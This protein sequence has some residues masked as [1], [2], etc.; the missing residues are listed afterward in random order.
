M[1][2]PVLVLTLVLVAGIV[3]LV[4][5]PPVWW[6]QIS[7]VVS[8]V[9][10]TGRSSNKKVAPSLPS[11]DKPNP[12]G[13]KKPDQPGQPDPRTGVV[14]TSPM[15]PS[16]TPME[17]RYPFPTAQDIVAGTARLAILA[18]FGPPGATVTGADVGQLRERFIYIDKATGRKTVIFL[19]NGAVTAVE[20]AK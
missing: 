13:R 9:T 6:S 20:G 12:A 4:L 3:W 5:R 1:F 10:G 17:I 14:E 16:P 2:Y 7:A 8:S 11:S 15:A 19:V 18:R